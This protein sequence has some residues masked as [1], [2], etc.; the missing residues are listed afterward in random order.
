MA[1]WARYYITAL[2]MRTE[3]VLW[4][5]CFFS[6]SDSPDCPRRLYWEDSGAGHYITQFEGAAR[7]KKMRITAIN[8]IRIAIHNKSNRLLS[9]CLFV[10]VRMSWDYVSVKLQ[11]ATVP[12]SITTWCMSERGAVVEWYWQGKPK[13]LEINLSQCHSAH[14]KSHTDCS[15]SDPG[16]L[17]WKSSY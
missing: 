14:H 7:E 6:T 3:T 10:T 15:G 9:C 5:V 13:D 16:P 8:Y 17:R 4:N 11:P 2:M 1:P 12:M